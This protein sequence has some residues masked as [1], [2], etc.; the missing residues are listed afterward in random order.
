MHKYA[1]L[2]LILTILFYSLSCKQRELSAEEKALVGELRVELQETEDELSSAGSESE[3]F[4]GGLI[5]ILIQTRIEILKTNKALLEQRIHAIESGTPVKIETRVYKPDNE[6]MKK[7][8]EDIIK[9]QQ[10]LE[11]AKSEAAKYDG[12][13]IY[14]MAQTTVVTIEQSLAML[15]QQYLLAKY[16]LAVP[17][18]SEANRVAESRVSPETQKVSETKSEVKPQLENEIIKVTILDKKLIEQDYQ[19]FVFFKLEITATGLDKK[20]RA[21]KG[22]MNFNDLFGETMMRINW[23]IDEPISPGGTSNLEGGFK[24]NQFMEDNRWVA[25]TDKQNMNLTYTV[26]SILYEDG[27]RRDF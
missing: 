2:I 3:G 7:I 11:V 15:E 8:Q 21:I 1:L 6:L 24:Y 10:E 27:T 14:A 18:I 20:A 4:Q 26:Q 13:L 25:S 19:E 22:V 5:K 12:G 17:Q 23:T 9:Q 16:G